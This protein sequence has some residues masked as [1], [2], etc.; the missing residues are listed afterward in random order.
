MIARYKVNRKEFFQQ[1]VM[2]TQPVHRLSEQQIK[3]IGLFLYYYNKLGNDISEE[4]K[5][6]CVFDYD[7]KMAIAEELGTSIQVMDNQLTQLRKKGI[8]KNNRLD[9]S[10]VVKPKEE[11]SLTYKWT[12]ED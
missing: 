5:W 11:F 10:F 9:K 4:F 2:F 3:I 8:V 12:I 1:F 6:K 7:I